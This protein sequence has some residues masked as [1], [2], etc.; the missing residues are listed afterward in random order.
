MKVKEIVYMILDLV[1]Q[2]SDDS[3]YTEEHVLFLCKKYRSF[4]IKKEQDKNNSSDSITSEFEYQQICLSLEKIA[5]IDGEPCT[6]G[7]YL[8]SKEEIPKIMD[9]ITPRVYPLDFYQAINIVFIPRDRMRY[10]GT[11]RFLQ[12]IIY[13]SLGPDLHLY[14]KGNNPQFMYLKNLRLSAVFEDFDE[15]ADYL[16]EDDGSS[17]ACNV[18][19]ANF[20]IREYLVPPLIE[21]VVKELLGAAWRPKDSTNNAADDLADLAT[22]IRRNAKSSLQKQIEN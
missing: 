16:C 21:L 9:G 19:E 8:R 7:Y 14:M 11:N 12:N 2:L 10:V 1:K 6:G 4:L 20:P 17:A 22:F 13:V 15:A 18:L 5:A 3:T